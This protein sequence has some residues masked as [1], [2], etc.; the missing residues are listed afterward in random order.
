VFFDYGNVSPNRSREEQGKS[1][2]DSRSDV[3]SDTFNDFFKGFRPGV[4][5]GFQYL[6]PVGPARIDFAFNP[7][8]DSDR[9]EDL[10]VFH[11]SV[12]TAF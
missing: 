12:G 5:F 1:P 10:F 7:D 6:L 3:I 11:L 2:Y 4:G 8:R 9:D